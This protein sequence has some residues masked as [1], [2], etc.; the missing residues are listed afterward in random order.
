MRVAAY[1]QLASAR[2]EKD[3]AAIEKN[4]RDRFGRFPDPVIHLLDVHRLR[5]IASA[6]A[7]QV[8]EINKNRLMLQ[9]NGDYILPPGGKF[10]RL[11]SRKAADK[12][13]EAIDLLKSL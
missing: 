12:L 10:P 5:V 9:R 3:L 7:V 11:S 1:R 8:V 6:K 4:W 2:S 13:S